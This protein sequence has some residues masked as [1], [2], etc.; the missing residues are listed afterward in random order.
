MDELRNGDIDRID[1]SVLMTSDLDATAATYQALGF[2]LSPLSRHKGSARPGGEPEPMGAGNRC[3]YFGTSYLELLGVFFD[4]SPDPWHVRPLVE[5][6]AGLRGVVLGCAD[7]DIARDRLEASGL[8]VSPVLPLQRPVQT[9]DG[10]QTA[11][12]R[13]VHLARSETPEGE[14]LLG[15][16][17]TP[18]LVHQPRYLRHANGATGLTAM[19]VITADDEVTEHV[20]RWAR[21]LGRQPRVSGARRVFD[22]PGA[23]IE[24]AGRSELD[25][26]LPGEHAPILP[27]LAAQTITVADLATAMRLIEGNGITTHPL[28]RQTGDGFFVPAAAAAGAAVV[29]TSDQPTP[30]R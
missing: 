15:E 4:G 10:V 19:L 13:S 6:H 22:M 1:H 26:L 16:Q 11:R 12:F 9:P 27:L 24:L 30:R 3:A 20:T 18:E 8:D 29:F 2:T 14:I 25:A 28:P 23:R 7:C 5:A 21:L 17:L